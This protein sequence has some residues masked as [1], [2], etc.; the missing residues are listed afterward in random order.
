MGGWEGFRTLRSNKNLKMISLIQKNY[1]FNQFY[2]YSK[3]YD[4]EDEVAYACNRV[5]MTLSVS[6]I[7]FSDY[8]V[9]LY[10]VT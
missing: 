4:L 3:M 1:I 5:F 7:F 6:A 8:M 2:K 10:M 9:N